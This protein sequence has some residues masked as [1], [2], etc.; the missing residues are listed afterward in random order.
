MGTK[1][2]ARLKLAFQVYSRNPWTLEAAQAILAEII[3]SNPY[4]FLSS[5]NTVRDK[6]SPRV[7]KDFDFSALDDPTHSDSLVGRRRSVSCDKCQDHEDDQLEDAKDAQ[8]APVAHKTVDGPPAAGR[9]AKVANKAGKS[10]SSVL[11]A[12]CASNAETL[13]E[14]AELTTVWLESFEPASQYLLSRS[15]A[16]FTSFNEARVSQLL[17]GGLPVEIDSFCQPLHA[18]RLRRALIRVKGT[19][20]SLKTTSI[21]TGVK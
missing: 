19:K 9:P 8:E 11:K 12:A 10:S 1:S 5:C 18:N 15:L 3:T 7:F 4:A 14:P 21:V 17:S 2:R 16:Q 6:A 13:S 20:V